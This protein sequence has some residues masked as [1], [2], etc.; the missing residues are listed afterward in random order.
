MTTV[1]GACRPFPWL[2]AFLLIWLG[3]LVCCLHSGRTVGHRWTAWGGAPSELSGVTRDATYIARALQ[4]VCGTLEHACMTL[5]LTGRSDAKI[6]SLWVIGAGPHRPHNTIIRSQSNCMQVIHER[7]TLPKACGVPILHTY[8][9]LRQGTKGTHI[10]KHTSS[11]DGAK[12]KHRINVHMEDHRTR[13]AGFRK[14]W[15]A[16]TPGLSKCF[17]PC[18]SGSTPERVNVLGRLAIHE[19]FKRAPQPL[20]LGSTQSTVHGVS[21]VRLQQNQ[22]IKRG[23]QIRMLNPASMTREKKK[24]CS[25]RLVPGNGGLE[26]R[27]VGKILCKKGAVQP[28][29]Q[30]RQ[31]ELWSVLID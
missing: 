28:G 9:R 22:A 16:R 17:G 12:E 4:H 14:Q 25:T 7:G 27:L 23:A 26:L 21:S 20:K 15:H 29:K 30:E 5:P 18:K 31:R 24:A 1:Y 19:L 11:S 10:K 6:L 13:L 3:R 2:F 8:W